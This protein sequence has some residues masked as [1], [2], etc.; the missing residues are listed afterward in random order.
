M[1]PQLDFFKYSPVFQQN[2]NRE[3][4]FDFDLLWSNLFIENVSDFDKR[5]IPQ[6]G[7][8]YTGNP[9]TTDYVKLISEN[10]DDDLTADS[11]TSE[12]IKVAT[13]ENTNTFD[14]NVV[15]QRDMRFFRSQNLNV[16]DAIKYSEFEDGVDNDATRMVKSFIERNSA[17]AYNWINELYSENQNVPKITEGLLRSVAMCVISDD[18][19][20]MLPMVKAA[21]ASKYGEEQEAA[22]MVIESWRTEECLS[23]LRNV[24]EFSSEWMKEYASKIM[25]ELCRELEQC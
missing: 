12:K 5:W 25:A 7:F 1:C 16:I 13:K 22:L 6:N 4:N 2:S 18:A 15:N 24:R 17:V 20:I 19:P 23:V 21:L 3:K 9:S 11:Y 14:I 10:A 8:G